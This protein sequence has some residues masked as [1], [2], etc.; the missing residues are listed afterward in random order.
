VDGRRNKL[1]YSRE[2]CNLEEEILG[3]IVTAF[4]MLGWRN[5]YGV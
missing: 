2:L 4:G 1:D 3:S 5:G